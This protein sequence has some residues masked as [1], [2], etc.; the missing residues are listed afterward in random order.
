MDDGWERGGMVGRLGP[1]VILLE[2]ETIHAVI[3]AK[4]S[5]LKPSEGLFRVNIVA[6]DPRRNHLE[7]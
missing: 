1:H 5:L 7:A 6:M 2:S 3:V 4:P